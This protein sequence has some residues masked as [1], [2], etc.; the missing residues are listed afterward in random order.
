MADDFELYG[1]QET[2]SRE[3][4]AKRLRAIADELASDNGVQVSRDGKRLSVKVP[5]QVELSVEIE[6]EED[7]AMEIEIEIGWRG[8]PIAT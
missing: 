5:A 8:G 3:E 6:Q 7:G 1:M 2:M 4:A